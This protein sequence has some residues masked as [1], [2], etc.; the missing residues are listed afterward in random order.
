MLKGNGWS[1]SK[2]SHQFKDIHNRGHSITLLTNPYICMIASRALGMP[3]VCNSVPQLSLRLQDHDQITSMCKVTSYI[4]G[5]WKRPT[6]NLYGNYE[7][8]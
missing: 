7:L 3:S 4:F 5:T 2:W 1:T 8:S 6:I